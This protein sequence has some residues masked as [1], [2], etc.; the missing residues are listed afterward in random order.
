MTM[1][2]LT[3][4]RTDLKVLVRL[5]GKKEGKRGRNIL[6]TTPI[7][8]SKKGLFSLMPFKTVHLSNKA[9]TKDS[10]FLQYT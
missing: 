10:N 9:I 8:K 1:R 4:M 3:D 7:L 5:V 6:K 2:P